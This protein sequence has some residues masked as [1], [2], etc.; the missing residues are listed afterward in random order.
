MCC[1]Q[2]L[3]KRVKRTTTHIFD[4]SIDVEAHKFVR[5]FVVL[6]H[7]YFVFHVCLPVSD[8]SVMIPCFCV[9]SVCWFLLL[10]VCL[11][12]VMWLFSSYC[13]VVFVASSLSLL[14]SVVRCYCFFC[15]FAVAKYLFRKCFSFSLL[16][17]YEDFVLWNNERQN[18]TS[19]KQRRNVEGKKQFCNKNE[20]REKIM[21]QTEQRNKENNTTNK[22]EPHTNKYN[23][24]HNNENASTLYLMCCC[25]TF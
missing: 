24:N 4:T 18:L 17:L 6:P 23:S 3:E 11:F 20:K 25:Y 2:T 21:Q 14:S 15:V 10:F 22:I 19:T 16:V 5:Y 8:H 12:C 7:L 13:G 9:L 1:S